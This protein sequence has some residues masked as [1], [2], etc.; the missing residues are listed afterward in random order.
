MI[1]CSSGYARLWKEPP[2]APYPLSREHFLMDESKTV[3]AA[4]ART[5]TACKQ[6]YPLARPADPRYGAIHLISALP[7]LVPA[8]ASPS[9]G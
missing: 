6:C 2:A 3:H 7:N 8:K 4:T 5:V 9:L 1:I